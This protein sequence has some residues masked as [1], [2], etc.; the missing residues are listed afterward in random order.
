[1]VAVIEGRPC[2]VEIFVGEIV[3]VLVED[4]RGS[5]LDAGIDTKI[6]GIDLRHPFQEIEGRL[7][8][9]AGGAAG[10]LPVK[11]HQ[12]AHGPGCGPAGQGVVGDIDDAA[13]LQLRI[14]EADDLRAHIRVY[15]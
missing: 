11:V 13:R 6:G 2:V 4:F 8:A 5:V 12:V 7:Q 10:R 3:A 1:D 15:P 9:A 14:D